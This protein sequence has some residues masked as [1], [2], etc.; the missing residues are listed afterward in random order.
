MSNYSIPYSR[1]RAL[2]I[3][4]HQAGLYVAFRDGIPDRPGYIIQAVMLARTY[5]NACLHNKPPN[6]SLLR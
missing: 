3:N 6:P 5:G 2:H 1:R 4:I